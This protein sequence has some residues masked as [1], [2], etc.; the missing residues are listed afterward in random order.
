MTSRTPLFVS[1]S[2][3]PLFLSTKD[4]IEKLLL[5]ENKKSLHILIVQF[6]SICVCLDNHVGCTAAVKF[7]LRVNKYFGRGGKLKS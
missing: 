1:D 3:F 7:N 2:C 6:S 5:I 4:V